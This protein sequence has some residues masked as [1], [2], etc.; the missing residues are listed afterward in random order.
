[1]IKVLTNLALHTFLGFSAVA[2]SVSESTEIYKPFTV[3]GVGHEYNCHGPYC[4]PDYF[5]P[6]TS[7]KEFAERKATNTCS[8]IQANAQRI[9]D[10]VLSEPDTAKAEFICVPDRADTSGAVFTVKN[11][12]RCS[13]SAGDCEQNIDTLKFD[14]YQSASAHCRHSNSVTRLTEFHVTSRS[15]GGGYAYNREIQVSAAYRCG[16]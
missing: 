11:L 3:I 13:I 15:A 7:G 14:N 12:G 8:A 10:W 16:L 2:Y 9:S 4:S 1:M 6:Y 5:L